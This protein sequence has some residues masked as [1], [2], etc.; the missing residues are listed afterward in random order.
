MPEA[1]VTHL[2]DGL[3]LERY[4]QSAG[5]TEP[6]QAHAH[7]EVQIGLNVN[8]GGR[9]RHKGGVHPIGIGEMAFIPSGSPHRPGDG[10]SA[11]AGA[12]YRTLYVP[13]AQWRGV[14]KAVGGAR[15]G[16]PGP[17]DPVLRDQSLARSL[18]LLHHTLE[19]AQ[20]GLAVDVLAVELLHGLARLLLAAEPP[21][22]SLEHA[23]LSRVR[24]YI[25]AH[26]E[27]AVS[28]DELGAVA[29]VGGVHLCRSFSRAFGLPPHRYQVAVRISRAKRL[30]ARGLPIVEAATRAGF[31]DQSHLARHFRRAVGVTPGVFVAGIRRRDI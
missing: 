19:A 1:L 10:R 14:L 2:H 3:L 4:S 9:Y 18:L 28:L 23:R 22:P 11:P 7:E 5:Y 30:L 17:S 24:E 26:A 29:G 16:E 13:V 6:P 27:R 12:E 15:R 31:T 20:G 21:A 25:H 8:A